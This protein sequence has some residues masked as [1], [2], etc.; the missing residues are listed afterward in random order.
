[1]LVSDL[2]RQLQISFQNLTTSMQ[3]NCSQ[4]HTFSNFIIVKKTFMDIEKSGKDQ[5]K[6]VP[7]KLLRRKKLPKILSI[8]SQK[9]QIK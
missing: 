8:K 1:M 2:K 6:F 7:F 4:P 5:E 3:R 9:K